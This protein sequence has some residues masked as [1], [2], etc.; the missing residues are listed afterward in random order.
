MSVPDG[1][2]V[3]AKD[4]SA[5]L[6]YEVDWDRELATG[7]QIATSTWSIAGPD[8]VLTSDQPAIASDG[9]STTVR[10]SA[11]TVN[12]RYCVTNHIVTNETPAQTDERSFYV[13]IR[14]R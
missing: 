3:S 8:D 14:Q 13:P 5:V 9:R 1:G 12:K 4:P 6:V 10:L 2:T 11:G 7:A